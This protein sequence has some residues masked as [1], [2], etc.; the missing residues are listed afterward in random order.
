MPQ[1]DL[2]LARYEEAFERGDRKALEA[3]CDAHPQLAE[4][5]TLA[6]RA[7]SAFR[8]HARS[9]GGSTVA[10]DA[11]RV[12]GRFSLVRE[13][14][15]GG[16]GIVYLARDPQLR[17]E[18]AIKVLAAWCTPE[19]LER[20]RREARALA[21]IHH[22]NIVTVHDIGDTVH[23]VP[24]FAMDYVD[25]VSLETLLQ[26]IGRCDP[27]RLTAN[28]LLGAAAG[29]QEGSYVMAVVRLIAKVA[30]ALDAA[31]GAGVVHRDIKP[32][33]ILVDRRG[34]PRLVDFG[35]ARIR[36]DAGITRSGLILGT[37]LY[38][39]PEQFSRGRGEVGV[40]T[41]VYALG[42]T[43][44]H[45]LTLKSPFEGDT[46]EQ[47]LARVLRGDPEPPGRIHPAVPRDLE[48]VV[49][50]AMERDP[51]RRYPT[52][53]ALRDDLDA[54]LALRPIRAR[55]PGATTRCL[56]WAR[57]HPA[58]AAALLALLVVCL[59]V[60][61]WL[62][63]LLDLHARAY[64]AR[65]A[66]QR[67][68]AR[69]ERLRADLK[70]D[71]ARRAGYLD[72]RER[73][74]IAQREE[75]ERRLQSL[76]ER[77]FAEAA[78]LLRQAVGE[79]LWLGAVNER[80]RHDLYTTLTLQARDASRRGRALTASRLRKEAERLAGK[81][82]T[83]WSAGRVVVR[84]RSEGG[85]RLRAFLFRYEP[86]EAQPGRQDAIPRLVPVPVAR[87]GKRIDLPAGFRPGDLCVVIQSVAAG[88]A[89][90][91]AGLARGD[92][93]YRIWR[94][95]VRERGVYVTRVAGKAARAGV[96][97][98]DRLVSV[99]D[100]DGKRAVSLLW[101]WE[102][103]PWD[104][105]A[106]PRRRYALA[107]ESSSGRRVQEEFEFEARD[108][109]CWTRSVAPT[110]SWLGARAADTCTLEDAAGV[111]VADAAGLLA[112]GDAPCGAVTLLCLRQGRSLRVTLR[113]G[114]VL[115]VEAELTAYPLVCGPD[116]TVRSGGRLYLREGSY[117]AVLEDE[118]GMRVRVPF[119]VEAD[120]TTEIETT[121]PARK[122][123]GF[124]Y[125]DPGA[126][127][128]HGRD[129]SVT[130]ERDKPF[131]IS[132]FEVSMGEWLRFVNEFGSRRR[133]TG[134]GEPADGDILPRLPTREELWNVKSFGGSW[135][136][137][138]AATPNSPVV[139]IKDHSLGP[140]LEWKNAHAGPW[141][142]RLPTLREWGLAAYGA[143]GRGYPWGDRFDHALCCSY[144]GRDVPSQHD[145]LMLE[146]RGRFPTDES[147]YGVCDMAGGAAEHCR[148]GATT[149]IRGGSWAHQLP[150]FFHS[151]LLGAP[152]VDVPTRG[153]RLVA[154][155][156]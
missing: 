131:Y 123:E 144:F 117:L 100:R 84:A 7:M 19:A 90:S 137:L 150:L 127:R 37:P 98:F 38:M 113:P 13:I 64:R 149:R 75:V 27:Q 134:C 18:V 82:R 87:D 91:R 142:F 122:P 24:Y 133:S 141:R 151:S 81:R 53:A 58:R 52:A 23:G 92:L 12:F 5:L 45:C 130:R 124:V 115:G 65:A 109:R 103:L 95:F 3:A 46:T 80:L 79:W 59:V 40:R 67:T 85:R 42:A 77:Q 36:D 145:L 20:F 2:V 39:A 135:V 60:G 86:Y 22:P 138:G 116:N 48:T 57:N 105:A 69:L 55:P 96:E 61:G 99:A 8:D 94:W 33:N 111:G 41:D 26:R 21:R 152:T 11:P 66:W 106:P 49:L 43:L 16:G 4:E 102:T 28:D 126:V 104:R 119:V 73:G 120:K 155:S 143:D 6:F 153:F 108:L 89:A 44:Y 132:R 83:E 17:R 76:A 56:R 148:Y 1:I 129:G 147:P 9:G 34:E 62:W 118:S 146:P 78:G 30:G 29:A 128:M 14:G 25:G 97:P 32:G 107:F 154:V 47:V 54:L 112:N 68:R 50:K 140:F 114:Q 15:R 70:R 71:R 51:A 10:D 72:T 136:L 63:D 156:R 110:R 93:I 139:G 31:H 101:H 125:I 121:I 35:V 88:G 74:R